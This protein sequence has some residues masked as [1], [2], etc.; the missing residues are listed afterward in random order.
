M[1]LKRGAMYRQDGNTR[2]DHVA[3]IGLAGKWKVGAESGKA[4]WAKQ[5][6]GIENEETTWDTQ[7]DKNKNFS[8]VSFTVRHFNIRHSTR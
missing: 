6:D 3:S 7:G 1:D 4:V 8:A 5:G 2:C